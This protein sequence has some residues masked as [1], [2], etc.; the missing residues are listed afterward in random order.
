[1]KKIRSEFLTES[2]ANTAAEKINPYCAN[3]RI[4]YNNGNFNHG[5]DNYNFIPY[6]SFHGFPEMG[7]INFGGFGTFGMISDWNHNPYLGDTQSVSGRAVL[8]ADVADDNFEYVKEKL[9][10]LGAVSVT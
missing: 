10:S 4:I 6:D 2:E 5:Y 8:E 3:V 7:T 9:Y 1:M